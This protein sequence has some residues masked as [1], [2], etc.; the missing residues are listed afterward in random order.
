VNI[1]VYCSSSDAVDRVFVEAAEELGRTLAN[2]NDTLVY[3]GAGVGLMG[4]LAVS[5]KSHG[6][7]VVGVVPETIAAK[8]I[9]FSEADELIRTSSLRERKKLMEEKSEAFIA[10]PGGFGTLEELLEILT[11]KQLGEHAKPIAILNTD[12]F[13]DL[14]F[15][16]FER[17]YSARFAKKENAE[18]YASRGTVMEVF[19]YIDGYSAPEIVSKWFSL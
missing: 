8:G 10:L 16:F 14:L 19:E 2:R 13:F 6:G 4:S 17:L 5:M 12:G 3:G 7:R 11:L 15:G 1:C 9:A 18:L